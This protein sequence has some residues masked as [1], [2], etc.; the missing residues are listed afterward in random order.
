MSHDSLGHG[1]SRGGSPEGGR[2][3]RSG[4]HGDELTLG[5]TYR[6]MLCVVPT[7]KELKFDHDLR[8]VIEKAEDLNW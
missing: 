1:L 4:E 2:T 8:L 6:H 7:E 3:H 5:A